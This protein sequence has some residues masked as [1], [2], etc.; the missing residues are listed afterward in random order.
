VTSRYHPIT[1]QITN[2]MWHKD[3]QHLGRCKSSIVFTK[4]ETCPSWSNATKSAVSE[5]VADCSDRKIVERTVLEPRR[6]PGN[7]QFF[8]PKRT[9]EPRCDGVELPGGSAESP[10]HSCPM[11]NRSGLGCNRKR[12]SSE[13]NDHCTVIGMRTSKAELIATP[14]FI[15]GKKRHCRSVLSRIWLI[16]GSGVGFAKVTFTFPS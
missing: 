11:R 9:T 7:P 4:R 2:P 14:P 10:A 3:F 5:V 15:A 1:P 13:R 12:I 16:R 8:G 6:N